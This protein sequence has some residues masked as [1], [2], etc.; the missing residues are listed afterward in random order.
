MYLLIEP[1][2]PRTPELADPVTDKNAGADIPRLSIRSCRVKV[3]GSMVREL[4][5]HGI[6]LVDRF[7]RRLVHSGE[8]IQQEIVHIGF[9]IETRRSENR[10][11][12]V[13]ITSRRVLG[14]GVSPSFVSSL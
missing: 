1:V 12:S 2:W 8:V 10:P 4:F 3:E 7:E 9:R 14:D 6:E 13:A 5:R 11:F